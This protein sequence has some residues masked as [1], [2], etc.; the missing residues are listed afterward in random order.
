[1]KPEDIT[2][3]VIEVPTGPSNGD[4]PQ[5]SAGPVFH[6]GDRVS[7]SDRENVGTIL[8]ELDGRRYL[9]GFVSREGTAAEVEFDAAEL[10]PLD[11]AGASNSQG[12]PPPEYKLH[13]AEEILN[14]PAPVWLIMGL[15][16][17]GAFA[18]L[19][20]EPGSFKSFLAL[21]WALHLAAGR[22]WCRT[23]AKKVMV[24]YVAAEGV[25]GLKK[26]LDAW[27]SHN[28]LG[29]ADLANFRVVNIPVELLNMQHVEAFVE[30]LSEELEKTPPGLI[31][32]D[33][34]SRCMVGGDENS[35]KDMGLFVRAVDQIRRK[36]SATAL[37]V[38]HAGKNSKSERGSSA[39]RGAADLMIRVTKL[40]E[41]SGG[42]ARGR[43]EFEKVKDFEIPPSTE[44]QLEVKDGAQSRAPSLVITSATESP[45]T[46][47]GTRSGPYTSLRLVSDLINSFDEDGASATNWMAV[48]GCSRAQF[49]RFVKDLQDRGYVEKRKEG[50][51]SV[52]RATQTGK[53]VCPARHKSQDSP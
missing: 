6:A 40:T 30:T 2:G 15:L 42:A 11:G 33:T 43:V 9:V 34:L 53:L 51:S 31:I 37:V 28:E 44:I 45:E 20:G 36:F 48:A 12:L 27:L 25:G 24:V 35:A 7:P 17:S 10:R 32:F 5:R 16:P 47:P 46:N 3:E 1:M 14:W 22:D 19:Y 49:F 21:D 18:V 8:A 39:L 23:C 29:A 26:R 52:Y 50:R 13:T 38:H 41:L 4:R